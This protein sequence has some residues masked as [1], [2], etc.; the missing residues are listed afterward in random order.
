MTLL[1]VKEPKYQ[2]RDFGARGSTK[3]TGGEGGISG[4]D[5]LP[6]SLSLGFLPHLAQHSQHKG[7]WDWTGAI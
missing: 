3:R 4:E 7:I 2:N 1:S 6:A 5:G